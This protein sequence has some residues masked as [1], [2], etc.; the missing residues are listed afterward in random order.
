[1]HVKPT[2][3]TNNVLPA[4]KNRT[5]T[6]KLPFFPRIYAFYAGYYNY[7]ENDFQGNKL[8]ITWQFIGPCSR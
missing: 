3:F 8:V 7:A 4:T 1:M 5:K 6:T 2:G